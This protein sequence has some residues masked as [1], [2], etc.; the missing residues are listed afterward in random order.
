MQSLARVSAAAMLRTTARPVA[1]RSAAVA[2]AA[3]GRLP[4]QAA[5]TR[6]LRTLDFGG[7]K[8]SVVERSDYVS[9][10][11]RACACALRTNASAPVGRN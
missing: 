2:R 10:C 11:A 3:A 7:S 5:A 6:G 4:L 9:A 1:G 8:E